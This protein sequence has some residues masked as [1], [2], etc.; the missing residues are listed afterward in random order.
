MK[1]MILAA[2]FGKRMKEVTKKLPKS[3]ISIG[4]KTLL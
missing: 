4:D 2:G 1:A 3:L